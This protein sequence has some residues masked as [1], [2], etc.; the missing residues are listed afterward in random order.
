MKKEVIRNCI[1]FLI[2]FC[3][4]CEEPFDF[5]PDEE[6]ISEIV[7]KGLITQG[8]GPFVVDISKT[9]FLGEEPVPVHGAAVQIL[10][11]ENDNLVSLVERDSGVYTTIVGEISG[12]PGNSY[13]LMVELEDG[14]CYQSNSEVLPLQGVVDEI[15]ARQDVEETTTIY[16]VDLDLDVV[17]VGL[18]SEI[19]NTENDLH[20]AWFSEETYVFVPTDFP[21]PFGAVPP[22]CYITQAIGGGIE[23]LST[24]DFNGT[25]YENENLFYRRIDMSF[26][27]K[28]VFTVYQYS[29]SAEY[30]EYLRQLESLTE[31]TGS[32]FDPPPGRTRGNIIES[33]SDQSTLGYFAAVQI[34][35][36][37][38][39][40]FFSD[41]SDISIFDGCLYR[42]T[43]GIQYSAQCLNCILIPRSTY[44]RP[45]FY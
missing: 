34:D 45:D 13:S 33:N 5:E 10:D 9:T 2:I 18:R 26:L 24:R 19:P 38:T 12:I 39:Q 20:L 21:D 36:T 27:R 44:T 7:I 4:S 40:T 35:T 37:R 11:E 22:S 41:L 15:F 23:L 25:L 43:F 6:I 16:G 32:L 30:H 3:L 29:T 28:H 14:R 42:G 1:H 8:E 31:S 17:R